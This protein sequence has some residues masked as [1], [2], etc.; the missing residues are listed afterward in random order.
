MNKIHEGK[1]KKGGI[2]NPPTTPKP[3]FSPPAQKEQGENKKTMTINDLI[4]EAHETAKEKGWWDE[5][6]SPLEIYALIHSEISEAVE[7][8]RIGDFAPIYQ[9][10]NGRLVTPDEPNWKTHVKPE[11]ELVELADAV[12]RIAD[13]CGLR[14]WDLEEAIRLKMEYNKMRPYRHGGK[15]Y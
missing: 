9:I 7:E 1:E 15:R 2:N 5:N 11:G 6:R 13:Y 3:A 8:A 10:Q 14:G 4:K 12:I